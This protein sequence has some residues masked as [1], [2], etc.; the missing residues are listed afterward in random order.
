MDR[1]KTGKTGKRAGRPRIEPVSFE[2]QIKQFSKRALISLDTEVEIKLRTGDSSII[3][4]LNVLAAGDRTVR[5]EIR[6]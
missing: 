6:P 4:G 3:A 2:A 1:G 5:V